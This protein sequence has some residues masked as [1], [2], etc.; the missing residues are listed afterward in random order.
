MTVCGGWSLVNTAGPVTRAITLWCRAWSCAD[1]R[2][3]RLAALKR[4]AMAGNPTTFLT[5]T[6]N[7]AR[8]QSVEERAREL[9]DALK[10]LIKRARRKFT[11][12]EIEYLAVFEETKK[13]EPHLHLLMRAP[14]LPQPW[15]SATMAKLI[16]SPIV[17][18]RRVGHKRAAA[19]YVTKYVGKGPKS[20][21]PLKRYWATPRY[22]LEHV[23]KPKRDD[24][25]FPSWFV[26]RDSLWAIAE[27]WRV[28]C[29]QVTWVN[30]NELWHI[31]GERWDTS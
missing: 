7:P 19:Q 14:Y 15:I 1:C 12:G 28:L 30:E 2:P 29:Y 26:V 31:P 5:L 4:M 25:H 23:P 22:D 21:G 8:G 17:D 18:I 9:S 27:Q 6:I 13:G 20:F 3:F 24:H 16:E 11:K 10:I